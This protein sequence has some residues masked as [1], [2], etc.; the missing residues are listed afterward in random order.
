MRAECIPFPSSDGTNTFYVGN[1]DPLISSPLMPLP[2][3]C[4]RAHGWLLHQLEIMRDGMV[5]HL[6]ELSRWCVE[7]DN[8]W[9]RPDGQGALG[10]EEL[11][12]WL[13]GYGDLGYLLE[14]Q[15]IIE[16][17]RKW[18]EFALSSQEEDGYFG[19]RRNKQRYDIWPNMV[20][21]DVLRSYYDFSGDKRIIEFMKKYF[22]WQMSLPREYLLPGSWQKI[23]GGDNLYSIH[24]LY[25]RT[26]EKWLLDLAT[27]VHE[28]TVN[29]TD[30]I[31]SWHGVNIAHGYR[32]PAQ[33]Y[34]QSKDRKHLDATERN[35][36]AVI[37]EYGQFPGG[38]Y[39]TDEN[40]RPGYIDPR[41]G[42]ETCSMVEL[43][44]SCEIL[45]AITGDPIHADRCEDVA[46][47]SFPASVMKDFMGLHYLT[48]ANV[49]QLDRENK[50]PGFQNHGPMLPFTP[51][52]AFR[53]CQ[54]NVSHGWPYYVEHLWMA[55]RD[56]GLAAVLYAPCEVRAKVGKGTEVHIIQETGYPFREQVQLQLHLPKPAKFPLYLRVPGWCN[57]AS[58]LLNDEP[59]D[60][61]IVSGSY[62][63]V[64]RVWNDGDVIVLRLPMETK[65]RVWEKNKNSVSVVR[66][67]LAYSLKIGESWKEF[68][69]EGRW[70]IWEVFPTTPWNYGLV[71][72]ASGETYAANR[73][74][75]QVKD[76]EIPDQPFDI[77]T[78]PI[79]IRA[80]GCRIPLWEMEQDGLVGRLQKSPIKTDEPEEEITLIPM[81][82]AKL[83][84]TAFPVIGKGAEAR[85]WRRIP[86][87]TSASFTQAYMA[88]L[89]DGVEPMASDD[90]RMPPYVWGEASPD[91]Y[92]VAYGFDEPRTVTKSRVYWFDDK[93]QG[94]YR[95][96]KSWR[97]LW[98][99]GEQWREVTNASQYE[100]RMDQYSE[101]TFDPVTTEEIR[102]Q[103]EPQDRVGA[104]ILEWKVE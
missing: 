65:V 44:R 97:V 39:A 37:D 86:P 45:L 33:Y 76:G 22:Q 61:A 13:K 72:D 66:G 11:P 85:E 53:C 81:G 2:V 3:G 31:K 80:R 18:A 28:R 78:A 87:R 67:P 24:W 29:W 38:M 40:A 75:V 62:V 95:L 36:R 14:D 58:V 47:N 41:Q 51:G 34:Q 83:R 17:T 1:R 93:A 6:P 79:E 10:W 56:N 73:L 103:V 35:Y 88:A 5:G 77:E 27:A 25:N 71:L 30:G 52:E 69:R 23:R 104:G 84:I 9:A 48:P 102:L 46:F 7:K 100:I 21:L 15:K 20:M 82:C 4:V 63:R 55:T 89:D 54:H 57:A 26:G 49:V 32:E 70:G 42:A 91:G 19:P 90:T 60:V 68:A 98:K 101:V 8:A 99:D 64:E 96:P 43:M 92:W 59:L 12:Y 50:S 16:E 74:D 94:Q